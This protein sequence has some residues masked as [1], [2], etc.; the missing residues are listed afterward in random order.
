M[1]C[2]SVLSLSSSKFKGRYE[3]GYENVVIR[4]YLPVFT[5]IHHTAFAPL[6]PPPSTPHA[7]THSC[8]ICFGT[9]DSFLHP[10]NLK[11]LLLYPLHFF[12]KKQHLLNMRTL[13]ENRRNRWALLAVK[14]ADPVFSQIS[15]SS[16]IFVLELTD[17]L[18]SI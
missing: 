11:L 8:K 10:T 17:G 12:I 7:H 18:S 2:Y 13:M 3:L 4:P 14:I 15:I 1:I 16:K 5:P 6:P 9:N